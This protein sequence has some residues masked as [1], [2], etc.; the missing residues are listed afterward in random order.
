MA[1][2]Y[3]STKQSINQCI[4]TCAV[5]YVSTN[6]STNTYIH[7]LWCMYEPQVRETLENNVPVRSAE[8][9]TPEVRPFKLLKH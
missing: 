5:V 9:T 7:V 1:V 8:W 2:V 3:V 4:H 6:Q